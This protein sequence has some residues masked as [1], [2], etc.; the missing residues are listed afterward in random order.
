MSLW[1]VCHSFSM[2]PWCPACKSFKDVWTEFAGWGYDLDITVGV[3][4][5]T[6]NPGRM[7]SSVKRI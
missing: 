5:V 1:F 4:D 6:E 7:Y 2:A 3:I